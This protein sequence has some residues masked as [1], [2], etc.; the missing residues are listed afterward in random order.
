MAVVA[1]LDLAVLP[2]NWLGEPRLLLQGTA[3]AKAQA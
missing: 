1:A 2:N 3:C